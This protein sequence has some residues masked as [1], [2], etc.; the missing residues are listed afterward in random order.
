MQFLSDIGTLLG[1]CCSKEGIIVDLEKLRAIMEWVDP[2]NV[3]EVI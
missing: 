3:D 1:T 2:R